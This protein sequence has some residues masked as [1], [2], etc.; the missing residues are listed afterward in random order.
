MAHPK[1]ILVFRKR[2][3]STLS[4]EFLFDTIYKK[5]NGNVDIQ[6]YQLPFQSTGFFK[7]V[8]NFVSV[9]GF[10]KKILH[11]TGDTYYVILG[12]WFCK[13]VITIHDLSFLMR[14]KG[15]RKR[16]L[17]IFWVSLPAKFSHK[18]TVVSEA[19]KNAL[20]KEISLSPEKI[21]VVYNFIDPIYK[22]VER[23]FNATYPRIL[24]IGTAFNKNIDTLVTA[25]KG[26]RCTLVIIGKL[27]AKQRELLKKNDIDYINRQGISTT[28]LYNE[29]IAADLLT[30]ISTVEG[31]GMPIIEAQATGLPVVTSNCSSMPEVAGNGAVLVNPYDTTEIRL[32]IQELTSNE[33]KRSCLIQKGFRNVQRFSVDKVTEQYLDLYSS[34]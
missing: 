32:K 8:W 2:T 34:L 6:K 17:K 23:N 30:F 13:R 5:L 24:Q 22:P 29:Y 3:P 27:S 7:R 33:E 4:I 12:G 11:I 21:Q 28:E 1:I 31:F 18:I 25:L 19:T 10:R 16:L 20:L 15:L 14:T 9:L 26:F